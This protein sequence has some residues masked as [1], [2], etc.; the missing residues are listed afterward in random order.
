MIHTQLV[1]N[2]WSHSAE[3]C[4]SCETGNKVKGLLGPQKCSVTAGKSVMSLPGDGLGQE[5][6]GVLIQ[7]NVQSSLQLIPDHNN[8]FILT[9]VREQQ[10]K[11]V[12]AEITGRTCNAS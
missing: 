10:N 8:C 2:L 1:G 9:P 11:D 5:E 4:T 12:L 7:V 6:E 3:E